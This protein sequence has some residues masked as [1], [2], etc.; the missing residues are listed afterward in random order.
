MERQ[1]NTA[2]PNQP[3]I[4]YTV[5]PLSRVDLAQI[6]GLIEQRRYFLLHAPRQTGKT[7][8]LLAL[9]DHL[10][11]SGKYR[12][13]FADVESAQTA[14]ERV[15]DGMKA[16]A[17]QYCRSVRE[18]LGDG[19]LEDSLPDLF[20][21]GAYQEHSA[22]LLSRHAAADPRPL[23]VFF[24][25]VDT[26]IGDTLIS[27]LRQ[28][29]AGYHKRPSQFPQT[30]VLCGVRD[31]RDYRIHSGSTQD[32]I[33]FGSAFNVKAESLRL[34]DFSRAEVEALY[35]QHTAETSQVFEPGV[36][37][38]AFELTQGQPWLTNALAHELTWNMRENRDRS[39]RLSL[40]LL[41]DARERLIE[42]RDTH[43]DQLSAL[44]EQERVR[45]VI[46]PILAGDDDASKV[47]SDDSVFV[48]DL[49]L[50]RFERGR[51]MAIANPIYR[52]VIPRELT[53][54]SQ[55]KM[56]HDQAWY[57]RPDGRLDLPKLLTAFQEFFRE[58]SEHW[59]DR[60]DYKEA[61]PQLLLQAYLQRIVN[62]G[63]PH[64]PQARAQ[65]A[66]EGP[67]GGSRANCSLHGP[68]RHHRGA[69]P[70]LRPPPGPHVGGEDQPY[71]RDARRPEDRR[72]G[73]LRPILNRTP[74]VK[75][76]ATKDNATW[77][78]PAP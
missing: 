57:I 24:D 53:W 65:A 77:Q 22:E 13:I 7:S 76:N 43:L 49:G 33:S 64:P 48:R 23:V 55:E 28:L 50:I 41:E 73:A 67:G 10:N 9:R 68:L 54:T 25:E 38:R 14:R 19:S 70:P 12:C 75:D 11:A 36:V 30:V 59:L 78:A 46:E 16:I 4:H 1:F 31:L 37:D 42:R 52:E 72:L 45:R 71:G 47:P 44:L 26:L 34:G 63:G 5:S 40:E 29:R 20:R 61:G 6:L 2:G 17:M 35:G 27:F 62:G 58:H 39:R 51:P 32:I 74:T 21:L 66:R 60:F 69:P 18:T 3:D 8:C 56:V 15:E